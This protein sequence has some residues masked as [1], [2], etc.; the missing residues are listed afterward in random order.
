MDNERIAELFDSLGPVTI[1]RLF[2]GKG[3]YHHG[4]I[5]AIVLRGE[6]MLKGDDEVGRNTG[7]RK[8]PLD[9]FGKRHGRTVAM[10]YWTVPKA[11]W[12]IPDEMAVWRAQG[13][14]GGAAGGKGIV[15]SPAAVCRFGASTFRHGF[16]TL[17]A[18]A[19]YS[20]RGRE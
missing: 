6:L 4:V 1:T 12:T 2:G 3:I 16:P 15:C 7:G 8:Q 13:L 10:P 5:V 19:S 9:L 18:H 20:R 14:R 11:P 17:C